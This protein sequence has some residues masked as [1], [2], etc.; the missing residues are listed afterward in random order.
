[1]QLLRGPKTKYKVE[2]YMLL[3]NVEKLK[4]HKMLGRMLKIY[5]L[6]NF[7]FIDKKY[8]RLRLVRQ[9]AQTDRTN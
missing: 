9:F 3:L 5:S 4:K 6:I 8:L 1:M 2:F 7:T